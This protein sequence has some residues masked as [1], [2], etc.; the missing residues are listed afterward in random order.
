MIT[1]FL[2]KD[3]RLNFKKSYMLP[4]A[5]VEVLDKTPNCFHVRFHGHSNIDLVGQQLISVVET[6]KG[7]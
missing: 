7:L 2:P 3:D 1:V 5:R 4:Y 6:G